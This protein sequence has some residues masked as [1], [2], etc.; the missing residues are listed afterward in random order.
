M[1][2]RHAAEGMES[3]RCPAWDEPCA[4][5]RRG[6]REAQKR[7]EGESENGTEHR[8]TRNGSSRQD[9]DTRMEGRL[10]DRI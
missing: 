7:L 10:E 5:D 8:Q 3:S 2:G 9:D 6:W 1:D 4:Q